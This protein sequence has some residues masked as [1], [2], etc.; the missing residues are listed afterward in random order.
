M[1]IIEISMGLRSDPP[2]TN[3]NRQMCTHTNFVGL[4]GINTCP[5]FYY[6]NTCSEGCPPERGYILIFFTTENGTNRQIL[7]KRNF[8]ALVPH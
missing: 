8:P 5:N 4:I 2:R 6:A 7:L 3:E 1:T